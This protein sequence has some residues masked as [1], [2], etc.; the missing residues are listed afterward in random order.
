MT[1]LPRMITQMVTSLERIYDVLD[2]EPL[3]ENK[4]N[5]IKHVI[6]GDVEF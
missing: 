5:A 2:E 6:D 1:H 3:I 4:D